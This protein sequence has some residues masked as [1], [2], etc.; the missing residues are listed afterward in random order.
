[1]GYTNVFL[2]GAPN[3]AFAA[4][5]TFLSSHGYAEQKDLSDWRAAGESEKNFRSDWGLSDERLMAYAKD[6]ID[7][8]HAEAE[9]TGQPFNLTVLTLDT[10]E[11]AYIFDYCN[12]DYPGGGHLSLLLL[13]D[14]GGRIRGAHEGEGYL[15]DTAVV[16]HGRPSQA[17][18]GRQ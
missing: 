3:A 13:H 7:G 8:L 5:G 11:P 10:H 1:M 16:I 4:K 18:G 17:H 9:R 12:V 15:D 6:E 14:P 2:G